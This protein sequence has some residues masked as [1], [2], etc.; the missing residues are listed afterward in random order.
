VVFVIFRSP[1]GQTD[2]IADQ[3][4]PPQGSDLVQARPRQ[5]T[6]AQDCAERPAEFITGF[7]ERADLGVVQD[8]RPSLRRRRPVD[9]GARVLLYG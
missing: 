7:P 2:L 6:Q 1:A 3:F 5:E 8:P 4:I 9:A